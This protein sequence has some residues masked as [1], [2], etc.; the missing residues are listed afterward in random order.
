[1]PLQFPVHHFGPG[2]GWE[3]LVSKD[4]VKTSTGYAAEM[5]IRLILYVLE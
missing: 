3:E 1:M 2:F 4:M 5:N